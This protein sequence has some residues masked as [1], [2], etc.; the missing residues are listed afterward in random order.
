MRGY[1]SHPSSSYPPAWVLHARHPPPHA[2][3]RPRG[4]LC[5]AGST[6]ATTPRLKNALSA[7]TAPRKT[8]SSTLWWVRLTR[9]G[10]GRVRSPS[11][12]PPPPRRRSRRV[13]LKQPHGLRHSPGAV[14]NYSTLPQQRALVF[15]T[16][17]RC[18]V[19]WCGP[20]RG[21]SPRARTP[22][23]N[24]SHHT[25]A[26]RRYSH[27]HAAG[28]VGRAQCILPMHAAR[29]PIPHAPARHCCPA[30]PF[31]PPRRSPDVVR[32]GPTGTVL[33][34]R[35]AASGK[36]RKRTRLPLPPISK[37]FSE[38]KTR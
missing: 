7:S 18:R 15:N 24:T 25:R 26:R 30:T 38:T 12:Q 32:T 13:R 27:A 28:V 8:L 2:G 6:T 11:A 4:G 34:P 36:R 33:A 21:R 19:A 37:A 35:A 29:P 9:A 31:R 3:T 16:C 1:R 22:P 20:R 23:G 17:A 10:H 14:H 5:G